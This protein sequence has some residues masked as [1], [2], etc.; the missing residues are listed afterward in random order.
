[1]WR[2]GFLVWRAW[3]YLKITAPA[4]IGL[5]LVHRVQGFSTLWWVLAIFSLGTIVGLRFGLRDLARHES[6]PWGKG[7]P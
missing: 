4:L 6:K 2:I 1:M 5:W 7:R 3:I